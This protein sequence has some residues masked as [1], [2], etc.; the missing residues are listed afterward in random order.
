MFIA[1]AGSFEETRGLVC[2]A[3]ET[4][5]ASHRRYSPVISFAVSFN[6]PWPQWPVATMLSSERAMSVALGA[7]HLAL[8][9]FQLE[10]S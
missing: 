9:G 1:V 2:Y 5:L 3:I 7:S 4:V 6:S 8:V 10:W